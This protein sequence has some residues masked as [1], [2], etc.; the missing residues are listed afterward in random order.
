VVG[1]T[2][3]FNVTLY[4]LAGSSGRRCEVCKPIMWCFSQYKAAAIPTAIMKT[5]AGGFGRHTKSERIVA[6]AAT[7][8]QQGLSAHMPYMRAVG[9]VLAVTLACD[10]CCAG[11]GAC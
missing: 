10:C 11:A 1:I 3:A 8:G 6:A 5:Y 2:V 7:S 9:C 4:W